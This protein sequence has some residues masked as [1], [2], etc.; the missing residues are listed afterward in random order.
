MDM[1]LPPRARIGAAATHHAACRARS[2]AAAACAGAGL[3]GALALREQF[4][5]PLDFIYLGIDDA[6]P[7]TLRRAWRDRPRDNHSN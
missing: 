7:M 3:D 4:G 2:L 5:L 6:L 1:E